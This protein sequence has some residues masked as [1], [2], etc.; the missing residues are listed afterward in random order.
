MK[1]ESIT[2]VIYYIQSF[3]SK[4]MKN[5]VGQTI[6]GNHLKYETKDAELCCFIMKVNTACCPLL[7]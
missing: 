7:K 6:T 1:L 5:F 4:L 2:F 3:V